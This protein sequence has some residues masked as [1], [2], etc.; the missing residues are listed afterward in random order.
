MT[1][2]QLKRQRER[3]RERERATERDKE[4]ERDAVDNCITYLVSMLTV[5]YYAQIL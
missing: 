4:R 5:S 1:C 2:E 3:E